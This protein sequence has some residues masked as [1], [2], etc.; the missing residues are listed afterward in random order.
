MKARV[1][2]WTGRRANELPLIEV[3]N[4]LRHAEDMF[5]EYSEMFENAVASGVAEVLDQI[6]L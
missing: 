4:F 1:L 3:L 5:E 2:F 6:D